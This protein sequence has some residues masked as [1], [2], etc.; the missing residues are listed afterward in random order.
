MD[1]YL[2]RDNFVILEIELPSENH[3]I[4]LSDIEKIC[5]LK[6]L[7]DVTEDSS[8]KNKNLAK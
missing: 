2:D 6:I 8:Y 1:I 5:R 4:N 3:Q 7:K